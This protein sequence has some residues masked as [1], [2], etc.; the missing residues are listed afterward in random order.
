MLGGGGE[1]GEWEGERAYG[2][3]TWPGEHGRDPFNQNFRTEFPR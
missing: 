1:G 2:L 3:S